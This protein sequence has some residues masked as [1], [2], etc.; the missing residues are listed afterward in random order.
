MAPANTFMLPTSKR[1]ITYV[2]ARRTIPIT[3]LPLTL[4]TLAIL[5]NLAFILAMKLCLI[6][7][8]NLFLM[9]SASAFPVRHISTGG[10]G[11]PVAA[12]VAS[13]LSTLEELL[14]SVSTTWDFVCAGNVRDRFFATRTCAPVG[15]GTTTAFPFVADAI[16]KMMLTTKRFPTNLTTVKGWI[17]TE[18]EFFRLLAGTK[19]KRL[20]VA[21]GTVASMARKLASM[22]T[23]IKGLVAKFSAAPLT[24]CASNQLWIPVSTITGIIYG[25]GTWRTRT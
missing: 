12:L 14:T 6:R 17:G 24:V 1:P 8:L 18:A 10:A 21:W 22:L 3:A 2:L 11:T 13:M 19:L 23:A 15:Q 7:A 5:E 9:S 4:M 25:L 20:F 16:T